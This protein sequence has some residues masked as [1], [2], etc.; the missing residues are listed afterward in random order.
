MR[1]VSP[2]LSILL[3]LLLCGVATACPMCKD[4][5]AN[6][7]A[8]GTGALPNGFNTSIIVMLTGFLSVVGLVTGVIW[9]G[10]K[11]SL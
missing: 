6:G 4:S 11:G 5:V 9:K 10:I 1:R 2:L 3:V 8:A 7:D